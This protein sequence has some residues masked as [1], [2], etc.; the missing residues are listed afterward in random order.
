VI[1]FERFD[2]ASP[3]KLAAQAVFTARTFRRQVA[4]GRSL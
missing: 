4:A 1:L 3:R 2:S